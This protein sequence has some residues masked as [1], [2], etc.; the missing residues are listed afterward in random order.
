MHTNRQAVD[1]YGCVCE[2]YEGS[3]KLYV[4][5]LYIYINLKPNLMT[6]YFLL[7][8]NATYNIEN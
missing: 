5:A 4:Y 7:L 1:R 2:Q 6:T 3:L 8:E